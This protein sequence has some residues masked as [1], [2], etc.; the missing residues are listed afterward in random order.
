LGVSVYKT[1][2]LGVLYRSNKAM[3]GMIKID[4]SNRFILGYAHEVGTR[5][6]LARSMNTNEFILK[7]NFS[8]R[9]K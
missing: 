2:E 5:T 6:D 8:N 1:V 9:S 4:I 7:Y 3:G